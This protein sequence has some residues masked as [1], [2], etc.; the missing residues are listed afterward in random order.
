MAQEYC[1]VSKHHSATEG[2]NV[3][4]SFAQAPIKK[5]YKYMLWQNDTIPG[6]WSKIIAGKALRKYCSK[7]WELQPLSV[8]EKEF[9]KFKSSL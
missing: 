4:M 8:I 1:V 3:L 9:E 2:R 5:S 7:D 6:S